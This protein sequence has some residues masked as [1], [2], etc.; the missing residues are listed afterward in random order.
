VDTTGKRYPW[1]KMY[2]VV[3]S[4]RE[5]IEAPSGYS[6]LQVTEGSLAWWICGLPLKPGRP[7]VALFDGMPKSRQDVHHAVLNIDV[8]QKDLQQCADAVMRLRAEYLYSQGK[9][10]SISFHF[11]SGAEC[12]WSKWKQGLRPVLSGN[13]VTWKDGAATGR[14]YASF[15]QYLDKVFTYAGTASL[16]KELKRVQNSQDIQIGDVF[17]Q[18]G[19][20]GHAVMVVDVAVNDKN[21]QKIFLLAQSYMPAQEIH[22]LKNP[23]STELNPWYEARS[24]GT[25]E[26]PEWTFD[27]AKHHMRF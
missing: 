21:G 13:Q 23:S 22:I 17:I 6:N 7:D 10:D 5:R 3:N 15:K 25:L 11:T 12:P 19:A 20:P 16:S 27:Y 4:I 24:T 14:N 9:D 26:T 8:G 2:N 1:M 18:G